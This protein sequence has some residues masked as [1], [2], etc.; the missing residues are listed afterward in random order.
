MSQDRVPH[1]R[2]HAP[3]IERPLPYE[4][5][6]GAGVDMVTKNLNDCT[7][8][9]RRAA[10]CPSSVSPMSLPTLKYQTLGRFAD[11]P[12]RAATLRSADLQSDGQSKTH[13]I[14]ELG[15]AVKLGIALS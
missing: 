8:A 14:K 15:K 4:Q 5:I 11:R 10:G 3:V 7:K 1:R 12:T 6:L 9:S 2:H 13:D